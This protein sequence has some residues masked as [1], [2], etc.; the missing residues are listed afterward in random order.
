MRISVKNYRKNHAKGYMRYKVIADS[1]LLFFCGTA[2]LLLA[3]TKE[4]PHF[5]FHLAL[6][7]NV[8]GLGCKALSYLKYYLLLAKNSFIASITL[9]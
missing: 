7:L 3:N 4:L 1:L 8:L 6:F 5:F 9:S 2:T